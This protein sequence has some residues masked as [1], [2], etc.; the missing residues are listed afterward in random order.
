[1]RILSPSELIDVD[2]NAIF[3]NSLKQYWH[4]TRS[5]SCVGAPKR[6][7]LFLY[8]KG[9]RMVYTDK[10]G[11][12][13]TANSGDVV[14]TPVGSE[15][16]TELYRTEEKEAYTVG[17]NFLLHD[18]D[19]RG[20]A[21]SEGVRVFK[22]EGNKTLQMIFHAL[23]GRDEA[24]G[25]MR[26]RILLMEIIGNISGDGTDVA[27]DSRIAPALEY[28]K[29]HI[30][31]NPAVSYLARLCNISEVYFRRIFRE[32]FGSSPSE[33]RSAL[34]LKRASDYLEYGEISVQE[35]SDTLGY[36]SVSHF[37]KEFKAYRGVSPL[38]YRKISAR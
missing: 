23:G 6:S 2:F 14:Y 4:T 7:D 25:L 11:R 16:K 29:S 18:E 1:M 9:F 8:I 35:I 32:N 20:I 13:V 28:L 33:Y 36:S 21:L 5:F 19:G 17:V 30:E 31:E 26:S 34:R 27:R 38:K 22:S 24:G 15:Y 10:E 37:I 12:R 3:I